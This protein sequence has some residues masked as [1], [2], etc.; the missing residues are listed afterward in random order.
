MGLLAGFYRGKID[1]LIGAVVDITWGFPLVLIAVVL[2]GAVGP[3]LTALMIAIAVINWAGFARIMRGEVLALREREF[4]DAAR[5]L[6]VSD[7]RIMWRHVLPHAIPATLVVGSYYVAL[8]IVFEAGFSFIGIVVQPPTPDQGAMLADGRN[9][10]LNDQW[11]ITVP[12]VTIAFLVIGMNLIGDGL[13][14]VF[15]PRLKD[16]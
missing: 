4:I 3:G 10:M 7:L 11:L 8:A 14:D 2:V 15:D 9:Y 1:A 6:G 5:A 16:H 13:R 12:G